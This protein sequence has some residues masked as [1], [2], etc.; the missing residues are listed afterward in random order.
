MDTRAY[1]RVK[2]DF[3]AHTFGAAA[4]GDAM[5]V[6][7]A[8]EDY[9]ESEIAHHA[10]LAAPVPVRAAKFSAANAV[11]AQVNLDELLETAKQLPSL[12]AYIR[13]KAH[14]LDRVRYRPALHEQG[15]ISRDYW[16]KLLNDEVKAS[17][18]KLL[19]V[20]VLLELDV[21]E[22]E[23]MLELAGYSISPKIPRDVVVMYC[24]GRELY[25]FVVIEQLLEDH[26]V[27]S[28]FNDRRGA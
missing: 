8:I 24:L 13:E 25:D 27:Q 9:R 12:G 22:A 3:I 7:E 18:E 26:E 20:A 1:A 19:R 11:D 21:E 28:L 10:P 16:S 17:K 5:I 23:E 4:L 15:Q 2:M 14:R 6:A